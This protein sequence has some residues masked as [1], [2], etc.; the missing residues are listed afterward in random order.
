[1]PGFQVNDCPHHIVRCLNGY[2]LVRKY[3]CDDCGAV[4]MCAC[5]EAIGRRHLPHQLDRG[6][7]LETQKRVPVTAGFVAN[8]C[9]TCRGLPLTPYPTAAIH[10]QTSKLR[11]YYWRE[12]AFEEMARFGRWSD[13]HGNPER[14]SPEAIEAANQIKKDVLEHFKQLHAAQPKYVYNTEKDS[15][16]VKAC[17]VE[18]VDL[19]AAYTTDPAGKGA[20]IVGSTGP[21]KVEDFVAD[22][23]RALGFETMRLESRPFHVLFGVYMWLLIQD[24]TD[25]LVRTEAIGDR[26]AYERGEANKLVWFQRPQDFGTKGYAARRA[27]AIGE[28]LSPALLEDGELLWLFDYWLKPSENL[29]QYLWAHRKPDVECARK[30]VEL[31]PPAS[32]SSKTTGSI[33]SAGRTS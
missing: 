30:V 5:D 27:E 20:I 24:F 7:E 17:A 1:M 32:I 4:M 31:L 15:D 23:Y 11:R 19:T 33:T 6:V 28:H 13:A 14:G 22:H 26:N 21:C 10:G 12:I 18:Q 8:V 29:R 16:I 3:R 2:E 25:P 9:E